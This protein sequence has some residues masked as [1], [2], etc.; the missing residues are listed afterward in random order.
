MREGNKSTGSDERREEI[1]LLGDP[2]L[3]KVCKPVKNFK[4]ESFKMDASRLIRALEQFRAEHGFGRAIA[5]PQIGI[6][7]Q[8]IAVNLGDGPFLLVNPKVTVISGD[9]FTL[10]DDCMSF[11]WIMVRL[12][13]HRHILVDFYDEWGKAQ[14]WEKVE[15]PVAE[16]VQHEVDHL[17]GI[18]AVDHA[19]DKD[20]VIAR[21][22]YEENRESFNQLVDYTIVPT[23]APA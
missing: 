23:V 4:S 2:A 3:R 6:L 21:K 16:L 13:R 11:P 10:W 19:L 17:S 22:V 8:M 9:S 14:K 12:R 18:L 1:L 20:S 7:Q 15:Q 5:A